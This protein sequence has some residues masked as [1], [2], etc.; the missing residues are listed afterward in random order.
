VPSFQMHITRPA[1]AAVLAFCPFSYTAAIT[2]TADASVRSQHGSLRARS[3][4]RVWRRSL[5][6]EITRA[7]KTHLDMRAG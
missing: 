5:I 7:R 1:L 2:K 6:A 4:D 3:A